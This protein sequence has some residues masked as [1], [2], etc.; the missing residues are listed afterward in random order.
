MWST[1]VQSPGGHSARRFALA[2]VRVRRDIYHVLGVWKQVTQ[3]L[4]GRRNDPLYFR[5]VGKYR[6]EVN[7]VGNDGRGAAVWGVVPCDQNRRTADG[8]RF[9]VN[10]SGKSYV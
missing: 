4:I 1:F 3:R 9:D 10:D 8:N 7:G 2:S 5:F 6:K